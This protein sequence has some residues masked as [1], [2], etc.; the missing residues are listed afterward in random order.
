MAA[1]RTCTARVY[2]HRV[3]AFEAHARWLLVVHAVLGA[4]TVATTTHLALWSWQASRGRRARIPG[5]RWFAGVALIITALQF[6]VGNV[7]YPT[8]KVRVRAEYLD[9][10]AA[11]RASA[12]HAAV[13][14]AKVDARAQADAPRVGLAPPPSSPTP[15]VRDGLPALAHAFDIKEH[16]AAIAL[17]A[18]ACAWWVARAWSKSSDD[19]LSAG[20]VVFGFAAIAASCSWLAA[21]VGHVV[22]IARPLP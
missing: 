9:Q 7:L 18:I 11:A 22:A 12:E 5:V 6:L 21:V 4:A 1:T 19:D 16:W 17:A 8:Y 3:L 14:R 20:R 15:E 13:Y 10:P 2:P